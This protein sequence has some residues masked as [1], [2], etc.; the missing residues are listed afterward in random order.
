MDAGSNTKTRLEAVA[1]GAVM[2]L[3]VLY[4]L[5]WIVIVEFLD[6]H[7]FIALS[8]APFAILG[9]LAGVGMVVQLLWMV[10]VGLDKLW[11]MLGLRKSPL[12]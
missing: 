2:E 12:A 10:V 9:M 3:S 8:I 4:V 7:W 11:S 6:V 1:G 5:G